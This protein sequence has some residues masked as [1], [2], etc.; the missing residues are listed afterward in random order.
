MS[1]NK[2]PLVVKKSKEERAKQMLAALSTPPIANNS[3]EYQQIV[4]AQHLAAS[5]TTESKH[6]L[7]T[8][9]LEQLRP[10]EGNPRKT[11]NPAYEEIKASIKSRGLD[12][13]PNITQRPGDDFYI[14]LDGGNTRLQALNELFQ[15]TQDLRF[16]TIECIFKP[17]EGD[18]D[19]INSQLN[20][21]IG[22]LAE[23][24]IR[25]ELSF[26]EKALGIREVKA[27]YEKK[28]QEFFSHRK[29]AEKLGENGY[30]ISHSI[31]VKMEQCLV[32]LYPHI[33]NIL[34]SGLGKHQIEK[35]LVIRKNAM[36]S[37]DIHKEEYLPTVDFDQ[38]WMDTLS[39]FDEEPTEFTIN[40]VQDT[41]IGNITEAFSYNIPYET[42]KFDID[43][44]E[45]KLRKL[46]EKQPTILQR[47]TESHTIANNEQSPSLPVI[48]TRVSSSDAKNPAERIEK[49]NQ[50][51]EEP[52]LSTFN[53]M[54]SNNTKTYLSDENN[55]VS[56][57]DSIPVNLGIS[58]I[59]AE[60]SEYLANL[61]LTP[62]VNPQTQREE[63][64]RINTLEF[65]NLGRQPISSIWKIY[66][67][68]PHKTE[69]YSLAIDIAEECGFMHLIEHV[70]HDPIDYSFKVH[71][72][73]PNTY[74][75]FIQKVHQLL[76]ALST[77]NLNTSSL[78]KCIEFDIGEL[79]GTKD[80]PALISD[81]LL[82]RLFR[83]IRIIRYLRQGGQYA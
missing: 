40:D 16:W 24:D 34:L 18:A 61:G 69:A 57:E 30:P 15:E 28:Y 65:A 59:A 66:P 78:S 29:L 7:V 17:W 74:S 77:E 19:D 5:Q 23:N 70:I 50:K 44:T 83:L 67:N 60:A 71:S 41:L 55:D 80:A 72:L 49:N 12:H 32:Y 76:T 4:Q 53:D 22:H 45:Q 11:K 62:G 39:S 13:A 63:E 27:L 20:V 10:Y 31:L 37:W 3:I 64:A 43:L 14:I 21:L 25:G 8:V 46:A 81:L 54:L 2:N 56:V 58:E 79:L 38:L 9:T 6:R 36:T 82:V 48:E 35:L 42:F 51:S 73:E 1:K 33:P 26:I 68:R 47:S 52:T 75:P